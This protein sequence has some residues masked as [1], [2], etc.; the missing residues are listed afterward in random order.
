[1][2]L[3]SNFKDNVDTFKMEIHCIKYAVHV[4]LI[5]KRLQ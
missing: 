4:K 1:M 2:R 3:S 5:E